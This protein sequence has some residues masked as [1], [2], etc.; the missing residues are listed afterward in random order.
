MHTVPQMVTNAP[1]RIGFYGEIDEGIQTILD[2]FSG[3]NEL[4]LAA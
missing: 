4:E 2:N 1:R 3:A